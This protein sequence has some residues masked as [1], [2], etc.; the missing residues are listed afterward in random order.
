LLLVIEK[1]VAGLW[2]C[3]ALA[4]VAA[5]CSDGRLDAFSRQTQ[6][7][8]G[9]PSGG[10]NGSGGSTGGVSNSTGGSSGAAGMTASG[11]ST[12]GVNTGPL[13]IDDLEDGDSQTL[14]AGGWWYMQNDRSGTG[15]AEYGVSTS[16]AGNSTRAVHAF[17]S[18]FNSWFFV[19]VD[20]PGQPN[21]DA[22]AFSRVTF[23]AR[24]EPSSVARSLNIDVLDSTSVN[25]QD[26]TA[27]HFRSTVEL[28][29]E[30]KSFSLLL[31]EFAPTDGDASLRVNRAE[32]STIEFWIFSPDAFD[33]WIDDL[34]FSP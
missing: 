24:A 11:G 3:A 31:K 15:Q 25:V 21:L 8:G 10:V 9:A 30:W 27:L 32:L 12:G 28:A 26:S 33:F 1:R 7:V 17:G 6:T 29:T 5:G 4:A 16:R 19:G 22:T 13:L 20:L 34:G 14:I 23:L 2:L 18:G